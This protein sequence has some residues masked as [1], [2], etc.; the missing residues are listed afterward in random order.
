MTELILKKMRKS[1]KKPQRNW[2]MEEI[3]FL[4]NNWSELTSKEIAEE[5]GRTETGI[6]IYGRKVLGLPKKK[7]V[8]N[9]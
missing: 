1:Y 2:T 9:G 7:E 6:Y 4:K 5:L 3:D 8:T